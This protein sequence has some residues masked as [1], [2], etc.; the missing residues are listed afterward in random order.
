MYIDSTKR[1]NLVSL[2]NVDIWLSYGSKYHLFHIW[3]YV[4][5]PLLSHFLTNWAE[6]FNGSSRD[7][8]L[9]IDV[10]KS[11]FWALF[12]IIYF[13]A[14]KLDQK[15]DSI[16]WTFWVTCYLEIM[17]KR[18]IYWTFWVTCYLEI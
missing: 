5:W 4:V 12:A 3:A 9:S 18:S 11:W 16:Y 8:Y 17:F 2:K 10:K 1:I 15:V 7:Y 14:S 6:I 13:W